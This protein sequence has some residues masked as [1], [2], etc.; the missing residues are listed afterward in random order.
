MCFLFLSKKMYESRNIKELEMSRAW[1]TCKCPLGHYPPVCVLA[2]E[3]LCVESSRGRGA[4]Q[5]R[6]DLLLN[7]LNDTVLVQ[8]MNLSKKTL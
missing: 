3:Y 1:F 8:K 4:H 7:Q 5:Q 2:S 6:V